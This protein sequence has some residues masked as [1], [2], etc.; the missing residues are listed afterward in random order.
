V[1]FL[2]GEVGEDGVGFAVETVEEDVEGAVD[3]PLEEFEGDVEEDHVRKVAE[4]VL[5]GL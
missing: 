2:L 1:D 5:D 4:G 3:E